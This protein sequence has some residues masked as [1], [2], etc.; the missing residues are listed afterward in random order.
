VGGVW[1]L[2]LRGRG[3]RVS[4]MRRL[5]WLGVGTGMGE[6]HEDCSRFL[7]ALWFSWLKMDAGV[8]LS[9]G[10]FSSS[11]MFFLS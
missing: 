11:C 3:G 1:S 8:W 9:S 5:P 2:Y 10:G 7:V 6:D 4:E